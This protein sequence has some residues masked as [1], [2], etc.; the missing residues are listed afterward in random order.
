MRR[1]VSFAPVKQFHVE[2]LLASGGASRVWKG[3]FTSE[4]VQ[5]MAGNRG[6]AVLL[7]DQVVA[8]AGL[9]DL[10]FGRAQAWALISPAMPF[11]AWRDM[12]PR[13]RS[14]IDDALSPGG[15]A[16]RVEA[17]T[18]YN[19]PEG[20]KLLLHLG[21]RYE[22]LARGLYGPDRHGVVYARVRGDVAALPVRIA[23]YLPIQERCLWEDSMAD[24]VP[25]AVE[26]A[27]R[28]YAGRAA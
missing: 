21:L 23:A 6:E 9:I 10:Q 26:E 28:R 4:A 27:W 15:W 18:L 5:Q 11:T 22:G 17:S 25:W 1:P 24:A 3:G 20:H 7:D 12:I 2:Q 13:M 14:A 8:A 16:H 19:W